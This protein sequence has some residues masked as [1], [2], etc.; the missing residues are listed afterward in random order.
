MMVVVGDVNG[1][2]SYLWSCHAQCLSNCL[3]KYDWP[4]CHS[5]RDTDKDR[6]GEKD[7]DK[8]RQRHYVA[9]IMLEYHHYLL[10]IHSD[11]KVCERESGQLV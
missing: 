5:L 2:K 10:G 7:S 9:I 4:P 6:N 8:Q 11:L 3:G 1:C